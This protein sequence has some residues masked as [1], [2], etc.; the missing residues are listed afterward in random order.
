MLKKL[1]M[2][3]IKLQAG[4]KIYESVSSVNGRFHTRDG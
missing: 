1:K 4:K 2:N 3:K